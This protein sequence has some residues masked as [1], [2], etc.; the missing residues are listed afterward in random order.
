MLI[1][2]SI[3]VGG[4]LAKT[5]QEHLKQR[6]AQNTGIPQQTDAG[7]MQE[8]T[9]FQKRH[10]AIGT[11]SPV[12]EK[13]IVAPRQGLPEPP[14]KAAAAVAPP[15]SALHC[16]DTRMRQAI[17]RVGDHDKTLLFVIPTVNRPSDKNFLDATVSSLLTQIDRWEKETKG[18]RYFASIKIS[19]FS[20]EPLTR[21]KAFHAL[22]AK[23]HA[24][25]NNDALRRYVDLVELGDTVRFT[26]DNKYADKTLPKARL[27]EKQKQQTLDFVLMA[28]VLEQSSAH[29]IVFMEDDI[30]LCDG[31]FARVVDDFCF[32]DSV[33]GKEWSSIRMGLGFQGIGIRTSKLRSLRRYWQHYYLIKPCDLLY[34]DWAWGTLAGANRYDDLLLMPTEPISERAYTRDTS[35]I[36][37]RK[38]PHD[39]PALENMV[40]FGHKGTASTLDN[41]Y[42]DAPYACYKNLRQHWPQS[43]ND[44]YDARCDKFNVWPCTQQ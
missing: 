7:R 38:L 3:L 29:T 19:V 2:L 41:K 14:R 43:P 42:H 15:H 31:S 4:V 24:S 36:I 5:F 26:N 1:I 33:H 40:L 35:N 37:P 30:V 18:R 22:Y 21:N 39:V 23:Y 13:K 34:D 9:V 8:R 28:T 17:S 44:Y 6:N 12:P 10:Q 32:L 16:D 20:F 27:P 25:H 11:S